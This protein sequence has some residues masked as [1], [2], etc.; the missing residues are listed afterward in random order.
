MKLGK[1]SVKVMERYKKL[2]NDV[3]TSVLNALV[4]D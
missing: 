4:Y 3:M 2:V 1:K